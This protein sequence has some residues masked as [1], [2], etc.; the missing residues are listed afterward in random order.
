MM[1]FIAKSLSMKFETGACEKDFPKKV[2][3]KNK[4]FFFQAVDTFSV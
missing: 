2:L 3:F 4:V 1:H